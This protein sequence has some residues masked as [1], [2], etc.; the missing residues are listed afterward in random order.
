M[1]CIPKRP[2]VLVFTVISTLTPVR[3]PGRPRF[4][5]DLHVQSGVGNLYLC[6]VVDTKHY[7]VHEQIQELDAHT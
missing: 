2:G 3:P 5:S 7:H 4:L 6:K 1:Y